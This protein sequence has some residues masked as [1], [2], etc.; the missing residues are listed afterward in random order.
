[1]RVREGK[2]TIEGCKTPTCRTNKIAGENI[3]IVTTWRAKDRIWVS[4]KENREARARAHTFF[5]IHTAFVNET[6]PDL[7]YYPSVALPRA[8]NLNDSIIP[9]VS[10]GN[11]LL[12]NTLL[13]IYLC[14]YIWYG[15]I[16][17]LIP[18]LY[19]K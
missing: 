17:V 4:E 10:Q 12:Y 19:F 15:H 16:R 2:R 13:Y 6:R 3:Y 8:R 7:S 14:M 11:S 5:S 9:L 18:R 1:M